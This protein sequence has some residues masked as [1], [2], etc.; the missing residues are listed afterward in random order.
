[1]KIKKLISLL[2][3]AVIATG[4]FA[5]NS[6]AY[7]DGYDSTHKIDG[8]TY[9][10]NEN[11]LY[12]SVD[13]PHSATVYEIPNI[14]KVEIPEK[15]TFDGVEYTVTEMELDGKYYV[16]AGSRYTDKNKYTKVEEIVLPQTIY[17]IGNISNLP[18]L[19]KM[20]IPK[21]AMIDREV[22]YVDEYPAK[23][24]TKYCDEDFGY[25]YEVFY[26]TG[27]PKLTLSVDS[28]NP[29]YSYKN[30]ML[31]S[32]DGKK[33]YMSFNHS[34]DVTIPDEVVDIKDYGGFGFSHVKRVHL[35]YTLKY[36]NGFG[37]SKI[38]DIALPDGLK[39]IG[40][41]AFQ[42]TKLTKID[43]PDSVTDISGDAFSYSN[44]RTINFGKNLSVIGFRA[45]K[46]CKNLKSVT[47]PKNVENIE[48]GAF[49]K[50][51]N[52]KKVKILSNKVECI[53]PRA[54]DYCVNLKSVTINGVEEIYASSFDNC[55]KLSKITINNK[56]KAP[57]IWGAGSFKNTKDGIKFIV[58]N[59]KVAKGLKKQ[60]KDSNSK[61]KN[62]KIMVGK[63]VVYTINA[64]G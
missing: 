62:A 42:K 6:F 64:K 22:A 33:L 48:Q 52:L 26:F 45:F 30:D 60:L 4:A 56:K 43:I 5:S 50:C 32:K 51:K 15:V 34:V 59:M 17:D 10:L 37:N 28:N 41:E 9:M 11:V 36:L 25:F 16:T 7:Y 46:N 44:L 55:K 8:I 29:Y 24:S 35:P 19:T 47:I 18:S 58:K 38:T 3:T 12:G 40:L 27:C 23:Y 31:L 49:R 53:E 20:N 61:L 54:F 14:Q 1:M 57:K 2:T 13:I 21:N 63:K 39:N